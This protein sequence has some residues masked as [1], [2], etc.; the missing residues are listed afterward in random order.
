MLRPRT[1]RL[2]PMSLLLRGRLPAQTALPALFARLLARCATGPLQAAERTAWTET[3]ARVDV[4]G[5]EGSFRSGLHGLHALQV[6]ARRLG[7]LLSCAHP[8]RP[9]ATAASLP[10]IFPP[11]REARNAGPAWTCPAPCTVQQPLS[12][13][14][15][16]TAARRL[17]L[18]LGASRARHTLAAMTS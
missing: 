3:D 7:A 9:R 6:P 1:P 8:A 16:S 4:A 2:L 10:A 15:A 17:T 5:Q 14:L 18:V 13:G 11:C 12:C